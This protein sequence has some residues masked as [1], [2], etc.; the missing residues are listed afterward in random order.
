MARF[1]ELFT[2]KKFITELGAI[3][4]GKGIFPDDPERTP[5]FEM[6]KAEE[7]YLFRPQINSGI[8][9]LAMFITGNNVSIESK[10]KKSK[11]FLNKWLEKR[12]DTT[13][14]IKQF[15]VSAL[16]TGNGY[17]EYTFNKMKSG[18]MILDNFFPIT[19]S[20]RIYRYLNNES[21][22]DY[23]IYELPVEMKTYPFSKLT[24][25]VE[26][27]RPRFYFI[28]YVM[29]SATIFRK[30]VY[31]IPIHKNKIRQ[32]KW[33]W[34]RDMIY[35]RSFL[36]S[37]IDDVDILREIIK[38]WSIISRYRAL[39]TK[40]ISIGNENNRATIDDMNKF[41][42]DIRNRREHEHIV[43]NKPHEISALANVGEYDDMSAPIDWLRRDVSSGL[44]P[45]YL[46][47]WNSEINRATA[48]EVRIVFQLELDSMKDE[49]INWMNDEI[50]GE[51]R[52]VYPWLAEDCT[53]K[54]HDVDLEPKSQKLGYAPSLF[55]TNVITLNEYRDMA[56]LDPIPDGDKFKK[57]IE[58]FETPPQEFQHP[59]ESFSEQVAVVDDE[60]AWKKKL[61]TLQ[62]FPK[63]EVRA[64]EVTKTKNIGGNT[65]R[66]AKD[67]K[68]DRII[69][70]LAT[71]PLKDF[72]LDE[73][74]AADVYF[75]VQAEKIVKGFDEFA[76]GETDEDLLT[77]ALFDELSKVYGEMVDEFF[78]ELEQ[79]KMKE[80]VVAGPSA[81]DKLNAVF[82][83]FGGRIADIV[84]RV[85]DK[86]HALVAKR[87]EKLPEHLPD[88]PADNEA[89]LRRG[90]ELAQQAMEQQL[91]DFNTKKIADIRRK[92]TDGIIAGKPFNDLKKEVKDDIS[93]Y[94]RKDNV[95]DWEI[96]RILR[97]E[98]G[99]SST[100]L[101]L[102]KW[103]SLGFSKYRWHTQ[104]DEKVRPAAIP[105]VTARNKG[106]RKYPFPDHRNHYDRNGKVFSIDD[107]ISGRDIFPGG[108][109]APNKVNINCRCSAELVLE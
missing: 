38:N 103:K 64:L 56:G 57:D 3:R 34:S 87:D 19:Q 20:S 14:Y 78:K 22:E 79:S 42:E 16:I 69:V 80:K 81:L 50:I 105:N 28:N 47:P 7:S 90:A 91:R 45:N 93:A 99:K 98:I 18:Q 89:E 54:F 60:K 24:G 68:S 65:L 71:E 31:G 106:R 66:M 74:K 30:S 85:G 33:G 5:H 29:S 94:K 63:E 36:S 10:D 43:L 53:F 21:D 46:T 51:L 86:L 17:F 44:V 100:L 48:E 4:F 76:N 27:I 77:S 58:G 39:N 95:Q 6:N 82:Q 26:H 109:V 96:Q 72:A 41:E 13:S 75:D 73:K 101:K 11:E 32:F 62:N 1:R 108:S 107:A 102:K 12:K 88:I 70:F 59:S 55:D 40:I 83:R 52:K 97:T 35:G 2:P 9:Q 37:V 104:E 67:P 15:V 49:L 8:N 23:W 25:E 84:R 61:I 92:L